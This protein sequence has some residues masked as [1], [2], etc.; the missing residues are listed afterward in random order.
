M[1][2]RRTIKTELVKSAEQGPEELRLLGLVSEMPAAC[3]TFTRSRSREGFRV[4]SRDSGLISQ[5]LGVVESVARPGRGQY[6]QN[7]A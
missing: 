1:R 7:S 3:S 6:S 2:P 4:S 5:V